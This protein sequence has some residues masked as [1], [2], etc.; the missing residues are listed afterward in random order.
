MYFVLE[1]RHSRF[2]LS[3]LGDYAPMKVTLI[4]HLWPDN[5][6][7]VFIAYIAMCSN[8]TLKIINKIGY[9]NI[10]DDLVIWQ[11][12]YEIDS[13]VQFTKMRRW[14]EIDKFIIN[15]FFLIYIIKE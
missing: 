14:A 9:Y 2:L 13:F 5:H 6:A 7:I 3:P 1:N 10:I 8:K 4:S 12:L 15:I 11:Q